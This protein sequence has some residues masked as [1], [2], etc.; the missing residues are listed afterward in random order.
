[1]NI[2]RLIFALVVGGG[3]A[4][5]VFGSAASITATVSKLG[6]DTAAVATCDSSLSASWTSSYDATTAAYEVTDLT[7]SGIDGAACDGATLKVTLSN[8]SNAAL[9]SEKTAAIIST[10]TSKTLSFAADNVPAENV[11]NANVALVGP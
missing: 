6:G 5:A 2:R 1:M 7:V 3:L 10:D 11:A 9:G 8:T 4:T